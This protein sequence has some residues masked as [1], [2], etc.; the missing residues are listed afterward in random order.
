MLQLPMTIDESTDEGVE[1]E[2]VRIFVVAGFLASKLF[3]FANEL[4]CKHEQQQSNNAQGREESN[5]IEMPSEIQEEDWQYA[6]Q[7]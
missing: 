2:I 1:E 4:K 3:Q 7:S 5:L 6:I